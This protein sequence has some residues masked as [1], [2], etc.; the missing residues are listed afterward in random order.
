M[1]EVLRRDDDIDN[2]MAGLEPLPM[3]NNLMLLRSDVKA[4]RCCSDPSLHCHVSPCNCG[5]LIPLNL[6]YGRITVTCDQLIKSC[7]LSSLR[8][9]RFQRYIPLQSISAYD[10]NCC[11]QIAVF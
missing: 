4:M 10:M 5:T 7:D 11:A 6:S 8:A 2:V 9:A 1:Y 3:C